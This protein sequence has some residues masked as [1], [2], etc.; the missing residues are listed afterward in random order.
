MHDLKLA[1]RLLL[2]T[3]GFTAVAVATLALAIGVN[4]AIFSIVNSLLFRPLALEKPGQVVNL[5]TARKD[6]TRDYRQFSHS[7]FNVLRENKEV[8]ADVA[9]LS[10]GLA[11]ISQEAGEV[12]RSFVVIVSEEFFRLLGARP[13]LGRFF[14]AEETRPNSKIPAIVLSHSSWQRLGGRP[15][16]VGRTLR[17]NDRPYTVIGVAPKNFSGVSAAFAP[18]AYLPL[19]AYAE[20]SGAFN[21]S[22]IRDLNLP[23]LYAL[24]LVGRLQ[25][26]LTLDSA[27]PRLA[28]LEQRLQS[29]QPP[30]SL[31]VR[32]VQL[33]EPSKFNIS[34][35]PSGDGPIGLLGTLLVA[36]AGVV[37]LIASLNLANMLLARGTARA[38][39]MAVRLAI[40]ATRWQ[41]VR[42]LLVEGLVLALLGGA[43]GVGLSYWSNTLLETSFSNVF[44]TFNIALTSTLTPD[45]TALAATFLFCLVATVMFSLGPALKSTR[46]DLVHDL[47]AQSGDTAATG[48]FNRF[49]AG[50]HLLVMAQMTLSLVLLFSGGLFFRG[51]LKAGSLST[52]FETRG[53]VL[54]EID[55]SLINTPATEA[56][57]RQQRLLER[58]RAYPGVKSAGFS[59]LIPY[60]SITNTARIMPANVPVPVT[61]DPKAPLPG[62]NGIFTAVTDGYLDSIGVRLLQG[63]AFTAVESTDKNSPRVCIVDEGM[64]QKLFPNGDALGQRVR[65]TQPPT[66]GSPAEME[67]VG[68]VSR[69][70]HEVTDSPGPRFRLYVPLAHSFTA[71]GYLMV[72]LQNL[73]RGAT[74]GF[75]PTL[76][77]Q[78]RAADPSAPILNISPYAD[79]TEK[80]ITLWAIRLGAVLFGVFGAIALL[81]AV[82]GIYGVKAYAVER[83]TR[84]IGIRMA[85]GAD[86][87][88]IFALIMKQGA[89][90][91][92]FST[93]VGLVLSL[94]V[95]Q[96]L[97]GV[98]FQVPPWDPLALGTSTLLLAS[99][100]LLACFLPAHRAT[101]VSP[102]AALRAE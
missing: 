74:V 36:M 89:Q 34:T 73:D 87:S 83:R 59:S 3:P 17:V 32:E 86:R 2:K 80:T 60:G 30:D 28:V 47:K 20:I 10:F 93:A 45:T 7:E 72:R 56:A 76:R 64:A 18:Q 12:R 58:V 26:G 92:A 78:L 6:A 19:G 40:G 75:V 68:I 70:R 51:A 15:D 81:L 25:T 62:A 61:T 1:F 98:L 82:V 44:S 96:V 84:E 24:N 77:E 46:A 16:I 41:V 29:I 48:R 23:K 14:N 79:Q 4:S 9:A 69:H 33:T 71:G 54:A 50:R 55:Y 57:A 66:D 35:T 53:A 63:R 22:D 39:E 43:L 5:Y 65:Y 90:Q 31:G 37:L 100:T 97:A 102:T 94:L 11:G 49:F 13:H 101:A 85:I 67:I 91:I 99:T 27:K 42:Q 8:F 88:D 95:G 38:R 21:D 52:G